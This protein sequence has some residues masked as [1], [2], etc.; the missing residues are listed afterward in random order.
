MTARNHV[1]RTSRRLL[2][3]F[4]L[5][6]ATAQRTPAEDVDINKLP[7]PSKKQ[8]VT[9][10]KDIR[11]L[12]EMSCIRCH[13]GDR[14]KAGLQLDTRENVLRGSRDRK[15][16]IPGDSAHSLLVIAAARIDEKTAMPPKPRK[17][18]SGPPAAVPQR[19]PGEAADPF[20]T[21]LQHIILSPPKPLTPEEVGLIRAWID[22]G[23][24]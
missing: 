24:K 10:D 12:L 5:A 6:L 2:L 7:P 16:V 17:P 1:T 23:A 8:G 14:A 22:Q 13:S 15:V 3:L 9:F 19:L 21:S 11:P 18:S 4:F 20:S